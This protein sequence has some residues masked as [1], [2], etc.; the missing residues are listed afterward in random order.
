MI[1]GLGLPD[2]VLEKVYHRKR[3]SAVGAIQGRGKQLMERRLK[4]E[5]LCVPLCSPRVLCG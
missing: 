5:T 3:G 4:K 1:Y 2:D